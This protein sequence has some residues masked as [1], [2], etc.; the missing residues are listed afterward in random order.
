M[1]VVKKLCA[2]ILVLTTLVGCATVQH[3]NSPGVQYGSV[4]VCQNQHAQ[5]A[6]GDC[7]TTLHKEATKEAITVGMVVI[8]VLYILFF[9]LLIIA[10]GR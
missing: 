2:L 10:A 4:E 3:P 8:V 9:P 5:D 1:K 7:S 6:P